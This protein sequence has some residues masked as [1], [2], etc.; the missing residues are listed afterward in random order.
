MKSRK[1][2]GI[3]IMSETKYYVYIVGKQ[4]PYIIRAESE[5]Q[6]RAEWDYST[7]EVISHINSELSPDVK[8]A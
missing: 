5:I 4:M 6:I 7:G 1:K 8:E 3:D 2:L